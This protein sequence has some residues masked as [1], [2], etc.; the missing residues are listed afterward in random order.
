MSIHRCV[1]VRACTEES[2]MELGRGTSHSHDIP[3][4][5]TSPPPSHLRLVSPVI[6]ILGP[7]H[8]EQDKERDEEENAIHNAEREARFLHR[9]FLLD[10][11]GETTRP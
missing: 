8:E 10:G 7:V 5:V 1:N 11:G 9:A 6:F 3:G 2:V 4:I